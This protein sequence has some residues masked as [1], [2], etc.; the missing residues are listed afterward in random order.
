MKEIILNKKRKSN[1]FNAPTV[2]FVDDE[3][4]ELVAQYN[5]FVQKHRDTWYAYAHPTNQPLIGMHRLILGL[6][7]K[8]KIHVDHKDH[9]GLNN[10]KVNLRT[11]TIAQNIQNGKI[12]KS[13]SSGYKGVSF[14]NRNPPLLKPWQAYICPN[15]KKIHIGYFLTAEEAA[16]AYDKAAKQ[17]F[18]EFANLN[19]KE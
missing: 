16:K 10:Q 8:D 18:G 4:Y 1:K 17:Y 12:F 3:D 9:D 13:S 6:T 2:A 5:W 15:K 11:C 19:F 14:A 7:S